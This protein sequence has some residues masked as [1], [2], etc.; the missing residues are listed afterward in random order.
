MEEARNF[1]AVLSRYLERY[2]DPDELDHQLRSYL[3]EEIDR[4]LN[5][6]IELSQL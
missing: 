5:A 3:Y 2:P 6:T 1:E 4:V